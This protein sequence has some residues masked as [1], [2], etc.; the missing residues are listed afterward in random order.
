M[1][2]IEDGPSNSRDGLEGVLDRRVEEVGR[3][4]GAGLADELYDPTPIVILGCEDDQ[5]LGCP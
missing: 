5:Q 4:V 3:V 2:G 1:A